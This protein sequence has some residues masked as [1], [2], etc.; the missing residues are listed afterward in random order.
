MA[1]AP[2]VVRRESMQAGP[3]TLIFGSTG[4]TNTARRASARFLGNGFAPPR[5]PG[6]REQGVARAAPVANS[7]FGS[8]VLA[9]VL[10]VAVT[11]AEAGAGQNLKDDCAV[12]A[13]WFDTRA[14]VD[15]A[16]LQIRSRWITGGAG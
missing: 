9:D 3:V 8:E 1:V 2:I 12:R 14:K 13:P 15:A 10:P 5:G 6:A 7:G 16:G 11:L 4:R